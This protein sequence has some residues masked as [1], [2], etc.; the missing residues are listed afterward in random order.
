MN[1]NTGNTPSSSPTQWGLLAQ[2]GNTGAT[3]ATGATGSQGPQGLTGSQ[4]PAGPT[5]ATGAQ[6]PQ[7]ATG[8]TGATGPQGPQGLTGPQGPPVAYQGTWSN[9]KTYNIGD[10]VFFNGSSYISTRRFQSEP[11][12]RHQFRPMEFAGATRFHRRDG[13]ARSNGP[14]G[15]QGP[16]GVTGSTGA[17]GTTGATG[18]Q[19]PTGPQGSTGPTGPTGPQGLQGVQGPPVNFRGT[20][21]GSTTYATGDVVFYNGSSYISIVS[22]NT[23]HQPDTSPTQWSLLAQ[24]G[25]TGATGATG[26]QGPTGSTGPQGPI[27]LT[28]TTGATGAQGPTGATGATGP[29]G[30]TGPTGTT[31]ATGATGPQGPPITFRGTYS[32]RQPTRLATRFTTMAPATFL[33]SPA[34]PAINRTSAPANGVCSHNKARREPPDRQA[35][36]PTGATGATGPQGPTG[37]TGPTGFTGAT[38]PQGPP[39]NF[40]GTYST[41][42]TYATGDVV[43]YNGSS[44]ISLVSSNTNHQPDISSSQWSLLAQQGT[45]GTT[46]AT[47]ATGATGNTGATGPQGPTGPTGPAGATDRKVP[48]AQQVRQARRFSPSPRRSPRF[49]PLKNFSASPNPPF[50]PPP[51]PAR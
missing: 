36:G 6:G 38:G 16:M 19:G 35:T 8:S 10:A 5:G 23:S 2:Q 3:G 37:A 20:Y 22:N 40:R 7:G 25:N 26:A 29:A 34:T 27:G 17:T 4:G 11:P 15:P 47:G 45:T 13:N 9:S 14:T 32:A 21:S 43:F 33:S 41:S 31:G 30:A 44:Y 12:A 48:L 50:C 42:G 28:G 49:F 51:K 18:P 24:Q 39:I 46:G 1:N